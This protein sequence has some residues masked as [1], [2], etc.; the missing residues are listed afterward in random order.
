MRMLCGCVVACS[1]LLSSLDDSKNGFRTDAIHP[2]FYSRASSSSR[3]S[4]MARR[5]Y[6]NYSRLHENRYGYRP[7]F[8]PSGCRT[9]GFRPC[10][11]NL[12]RCPYLQI[13]FMGT[14]KNPH[15]GHRIAEGPHS[16]IGKKPPTLGGDKRG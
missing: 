10:Y 15:A 16:S 2:F 1:V 7:F 14:S 8:R 3:R 5:A 6:G 4:C 13:S 11:F 9:R 12:D